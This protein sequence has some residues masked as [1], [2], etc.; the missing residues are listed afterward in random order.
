MTQTAELTGLTLAVPAIK[1]AK[2]AA[3]IR[4]GGQNNSRRLAAG[5]SGAWQKTWGQE[6]STSF[7]KLASG[8]R[9]DA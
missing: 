2:G 9:I 8:V 4:I 6:Y 5:D 1:S 7:R 3:C